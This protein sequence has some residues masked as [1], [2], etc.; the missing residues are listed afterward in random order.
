MPDTWTYYIDAA[1]NLIIRDYANQ[2]IVLLTPEMTRELRDFILE[3]FRELPN[4]QS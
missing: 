2:Q 3:E 4:L 1:G